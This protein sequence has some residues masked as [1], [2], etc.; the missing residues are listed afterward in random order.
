M[1][2]RMTLVDSS[3]FIGTDR[4][5]A[6]CNVVVAELLA[7]YRTPAEYRKVQLALGELV[8]LPLTDECGARAAAFGFSLHRSGV[9][10]PLVD[11]LLAATARVHGADLLYC[12]A[13]FELIG[14][15]PDTLA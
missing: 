15:T 11:R 12:D 5:P 4:R 2:R 7:G 6:T 14:R 3:A 1:A 13:H 9:T 8:W 10:V